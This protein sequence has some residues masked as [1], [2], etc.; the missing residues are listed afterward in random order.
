M[1]VS[2][3]IIT[4]NHHRFISQALESV[5]AQKV[6]FDYE[7]VVGEDCS[8]DG[9]RAILM[10]FHRHYPG[11][12]FPLLRNRNV[13]AMQNLR[14]TLAACRGQYVALLE[15]DDY[16]TNDQKL[17]KQVDFLDGHPDCA[18]CCHRV[19]FLDEKS[20]DEVFP[21]FRAGSYTIEDLLKGNFV[22]TCSTVLRRNFVGAIPDWFSRMKLGDWPLFALVARHGNIELMDEIMAR[23]RVHGGGIWTSMPQTA[24][25]KAGTQMLK[26]LDKHFGFRYTDI[27]RETIAR[28]YLGMA[29][30][31]QASGRRTDTARY[32]YTCL[33][34]GG[35]QFGESRRT[36]IALAAYAL[37]GP[38]YK[39]FSRSKSANPN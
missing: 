34:N 27:I 33:R 24:R 13:G 28:P 9:T 36:M 35:W 8:T 23:Y 15:G 6:D 16:W 20:T 11:R 30:A 17:Q 37:V 21:S 38:R 1:K 29:M 14:E 18:L 19:R 5:L 39:L 3:M 12:I 32:L 2:V 31:A 7:I 26:A 22:M 10:D 25:M 4:Y